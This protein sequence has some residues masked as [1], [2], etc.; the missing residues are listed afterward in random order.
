MERCA[1]VDD[2][3]PPHRVSKEL[4]ATLR[5]FGM[6]RDALTNQI[7][8]SG[9][10]DWEESI[11]RATREA[12]TE[13]LLNRRYPFNAGWCVREIGN[14][15]WVIS[16]FMPWL[17]AECDWI[18]LKTATEADGVAVRV[19]I[20]DVD[21]F[22]ALLCEVYVRLEKGLLKIASRE[23]AWR[24]KE[25]I[26]QDAVLAAVKRFREGE[27]FKN[28]L[29]ESIRAYLIRVCKYRRQQ[30]LR[31]EMCYI[32]ARPSG[33][34]D[35]NGAHGPPSGHAGEPQEGALNLVE[36][37]AIREQEER[38][39]VELLTEI[40]IQRGCTVRAEEVLTVINSLPSRQRQA[41]LG[42][43]DHEVLGGLSPGE[44]AE[45][46]GMHPRSYS[47]NKSR[48]RRRVRELLE[49]TPG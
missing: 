40:L 9:W 31:E 13:A 44:A 2:K 12:V 26:V 1:M 37:R 29:V 48:A 11:L 19:L 47:V 20:G 10:S 45:L 17:F 21:A 24:W 5:L 33:F 27:G 22:Q 7:E 15:D 36:R 8:V 3:K 28:P 23:G 14:R 18:G 39:S 34:A 49:E 38:S 41:Y 6:C 35:M 46:V 16:A 42:Y 32:P 43:L 30:K 4:G 25:E